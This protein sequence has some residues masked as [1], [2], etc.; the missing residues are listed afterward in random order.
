MV[1]CENMENPNFSYNEEYLDS[2]SYSVSS[3]SD[4]NRRKRST[5]E[6]CT[7]DT[8]FSQVTDIFV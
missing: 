1:Q 6:E 8:I 5:D 7:L 3:Y 4:Y 2:S